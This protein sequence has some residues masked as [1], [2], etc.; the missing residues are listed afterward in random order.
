MYFYP[1]LVLRGTLVLK[2]ICLQNALNEAFLCIGGTKQKVD[3]R[4]ISR[5]RT[6][7][8]VHSIL[9]IR[10]TALTSCRPARCQLPRYAICTKLHAAKLH[11]GDST[12][13]IVN[14]NPSWYCAISSFATRRSTW[15]LFSSLLMHI[16]KLKWSS[17]VKSGVK[18][19]PCV[20]LRSGNFPCHTSPITW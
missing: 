18:L 3:A 11:H 15:F 20:L 16:M 5:H 14:P 4:E 13:L 10:T 7:Q 19:V 8:Y 9:P 17:P 2:Q 1:S 6:I 12:P